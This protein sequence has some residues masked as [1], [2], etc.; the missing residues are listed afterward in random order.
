MNFHRIHL[1]NDLEIKKVRITQQLSPSALPTPRELQIWFLNPYITFAYFCTV[2]I[3]NYCTS[4]KLYV[5][6]YF[7]VWILAWKNKRKIVSR[8]TIIF[9]LCPYSETHWHEHI[10]PSV[11]SICMLSLCIQGKISNMKLIWRDTR[12]FSR[13]GHWPRLTVTNPLPWIKD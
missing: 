7:K 3:Q 5:Y 8:H 4:H 1:L 12:P 11:L 2:H 13:L 9:R 6:M 10:V